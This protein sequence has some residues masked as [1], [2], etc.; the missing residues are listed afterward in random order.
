[1]R[2]F[3]D[4]EDQTWIALLLLPAIL[5]IATT[6][7]GLRKWIARPERMQILQENYDL[8]CENIKLKSK[9]RLQQMEIEKLKKG[10]KTSYRRHTKRI[11]VSAYSLRENETDSDP[12]W[13]ALG[14]TVYGQAAVAPAML[15]SG[16]FRRGDHILILTKEGKRYFRVINDKMNPRYKSNIDLLFKDTYSAKL[17]GRKDALVVNLTKVNHE[18]SSLW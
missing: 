5:L 9:L 10:V 3:V 15:H 17:F 14:P 18:L 4:Y 7:Y 16:E 2:P 8:T 1:M 12:E 11:E 6:G 13:S